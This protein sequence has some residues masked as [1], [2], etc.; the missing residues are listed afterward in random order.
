MTSAETDGS[1]FTGANLPGAGLAGA[2]TAGSSF[3]DGNLSGAD[4]A[5]SVICRWSLP[6]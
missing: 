2:D 3:K 1:T 6:C 4:L 5:R